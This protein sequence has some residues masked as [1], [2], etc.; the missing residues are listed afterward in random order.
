MT[1]SKTPEEWEEN[2]KLLQQNEDKFHAVGMAMA[3][4]K[5]DLDQDSW[6]KLQDELTL[7][8]VKSLRT[9]REKLVEEAGKVISD[10]KNRYSDYYILDSCIEEIKDKLTT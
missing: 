8:L 5:V 9:G 7:L 4:T 2:R 6:L 1:K 3:R 10:L